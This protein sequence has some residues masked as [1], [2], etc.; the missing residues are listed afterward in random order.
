MRSWRLPIVQTVPFRIL[1]QDGCTAEFWL[2]WIGWSLA[3]SIVYPGRSGSPTIY[4]TLPVW[5]I[6]HRTLPSEDPRFAANGLCSGFDISCRLELSIFGRPRRR[7]GLSLS[8]TWHCWLVL[9]WYRSPPCVWCHE[10]RWRSNWFLLLKHDSQELN[11]CH[12]KWGFD[13]FQ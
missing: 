6:L 12:L 7:R 2:F 1:W 3:L 9:I 10:A 4:E 13:R 5:L 11:L 8:G